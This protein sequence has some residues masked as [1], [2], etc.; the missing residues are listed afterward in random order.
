M[1]AQ[2]SG[3]GQP[4]ESFLRVMF[5]ASF[6]LQSRCGVSCKI[7]LQIRAFLHH[8]TIA[9]LQRMWTRQIQIMMEWVTHATTVCQTKTLIRRTPMATVRAMLAMMTK[10]EMVGALLSILRALGSPIGAEIEFNMVSW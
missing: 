9:S 10:T 1:I 8:R 5:S 4:L 6:L 7:P 3:L 2:S